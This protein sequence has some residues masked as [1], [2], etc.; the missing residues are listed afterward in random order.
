MKVG[1]LVM[2]RNCAQ[3]GEF[4]IISIVPKHDT[5]YPPGC[6]L[7]WVVSDTGMQCFTGNQLV[8]R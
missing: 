6:W 7:Y 5:S 8:A 3:E 4:G 2:F 1:D